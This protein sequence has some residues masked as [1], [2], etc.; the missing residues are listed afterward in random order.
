VAG[1]G[2]FHPV[3]SNDTEEG[4]RLNRRVDIVVVAVEAP[5]ML[6]AP[7]PQQ[8]NSREMLPKTTNSGNRTIALSAPQTSKL[9]SEGIGSDR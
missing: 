6:K 9:P 5:Q 2:E 7:E 1:Y 8:A 4:R 3:A